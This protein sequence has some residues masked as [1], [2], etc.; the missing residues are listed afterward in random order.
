[1]KILSEAKIGVDLSHFRG[2]CGV[3]IKNLFEKKM[4][5]LSYKLKL[6]VSKLF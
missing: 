5:K 1:M 2:A 3:K 6:I 4:A